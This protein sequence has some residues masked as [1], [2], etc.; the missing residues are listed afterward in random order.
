M[1]ERSSSILAVYEILQLNQPQSKAQCPSW[2]LAISVKIS[3]HRLIQQANKL[4]QSFFGR[5]FKDSRSGQACIGA[6][7]CEE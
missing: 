4:L 2:P 7:D 5:A 6:W 1:L 3:Q